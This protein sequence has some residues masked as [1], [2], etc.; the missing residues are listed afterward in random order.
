MILL[1]FKFISLFI[2]FFT[3]LWVF[4]DTIY[5]YILLPHY[6][7]KRKRKRDHGFLYHVYFTLP[8]LI[9]QNIEDR[10]SNEFKEHGFILFSG[11]QGSG[12]TMAMT[13]YIKQLQNKYDRVKVYT[14][15]GYLNQS[16][17]LVDYHQLIDLNNGLD[18]I[19]F[20]FDEIQATFSS[21]NWKDN[22]DPSLLAC[23]CQN[24]KS[25][26]LIYGTC[27]N[28]QLVDKSIRIQCMKFAKCFT[29]FG[30]LTLVVFFEPEYDFEGNLSKS[31]FRGLKF[32]FQTKELRSYYDTFLL[33][34]SIK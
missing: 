18:G 27:Q 28:I 33:I 6:R 24:R 16:D 1:I 8:Y 30:F 22:F 34:Q 11:K 5:Q 10:L 14:N 7:I 32:F 19:C 9:A 4:I 25:H 23:I 15:Y 26:R 21:R 3:L 13:Y 29:F 31:K 20:G 17:F 12:K 2:F